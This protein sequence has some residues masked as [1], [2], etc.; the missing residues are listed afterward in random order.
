MTEFME[1]PTGNLPV[2]K[3]SLAQHHLCH[4]YQYQNEN[5]ELISTL[6]S[7]KIN[8]DVT[9]VSETCNSFDNPIKN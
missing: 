2:L 9:G 8:F 6:A 5:D 4:I 7:L 3:L 1:G